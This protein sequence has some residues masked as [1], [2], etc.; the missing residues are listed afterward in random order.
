MKISKRSTTTILFVLFFLF[1]GCSNQV[2]KRRP[3]IIFISL[4][5]FRPDLVGKLDKSQTPVTPHISALAKESVVFKNAFAQIP[6]TLPSHMS[7]FTGLYPDA[8]GVVDENKSLPASIKTLPQHLQQNGYSTFGF[9]T[10]DW[11][12]K[13]FG[14][15][16]GF[17]HYE[18]IYVSQNFTFADQV[19]DRAL[20]ALASADPERPFFIFLHYF[21]AHSDFTNR[22]NKLPYFSPNSFRND[23]NLPANTDEFCDV[24]GNCATAFLQNL[25]KKREPLPPATVQTIFELYIRG[26]KYLDEELGRLFTA[27]QSRRFFDESLIIVTSDHGEE[28]REH[29][30]FIHSQSYDETIAIPLIIRF[31]NGDHGGTVSE[32]LAESIDF[33]PTILAYLGISYD[34]PVQGQ[35]LLPTILT[36]TPSKSSVLS[37]DKIKKQR[38]ALR[39]ADLKFIHNFATGQSELYNLDQD[40]YELEDLS[41][42][43]QVRITGLRNELRRMIST[44]LKLAESI[45]SSATDS[46]ILSEE[47]RKR[48]RS[49]GY[50]E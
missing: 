17:D 48:L 2:D 6:F 13:E 8:H 41:A 20:R 36:G 40:P 46:E 23:L 35:N 4:D 14:F 34:Q 9:F 42:E 19:N 45:N 18:R 11:L 28:F 37:Q 24:L 16:S 26:A 25:N 30:R 1:S 50:L 12:K 3:N 43:N 33:L 21:D 5:T 27:L 7:M 22:K 49:I 39:A 10:T 44:N 32:E 38:Y 47:E 15:G 31:P 29:G